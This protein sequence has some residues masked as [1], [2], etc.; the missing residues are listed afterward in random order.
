M[1][2]ILPY[3]KFKLNEAV[4]YVDIYTSNETVK[5]GAAYNNK[6]KMGAVR[7]VGKHGTK[8]YKIDVAIPIIY[9]GPVQPVKITKKLTNSGNSSEYTIYTSVDGQ[10]HTLDKDDVVKLVN[11]YN[12]KNNSTTIGRATFTRTWKFSDIT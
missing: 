8:D 12:S 11:L 9:T 10:K 3:N 5:V 1:I 4:S 6:S 7:L 2:Y